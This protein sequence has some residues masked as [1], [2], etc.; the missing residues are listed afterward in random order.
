MYTRSLKGHSRL[1]KKCC[2]A[3]TMG[4]KISQFENPLA[5]LKARNF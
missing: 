1:L 4:V 3:H 5:T 2:L